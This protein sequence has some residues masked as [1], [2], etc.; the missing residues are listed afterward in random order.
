MNV[1]VGASVVFENHA[2]SAA[3]Q[4]LIPKLGV[5]S[6]HADARVRADACHYLGLAGDAAARVYL[7]LRL[8]DKNAEVR[9]I[10][11]DSLE[12]LAAAGV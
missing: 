2:G 7:G 5:L 12:T 11:A 3:L 6:A 10:A 1:R 9:E 8:A 4:T